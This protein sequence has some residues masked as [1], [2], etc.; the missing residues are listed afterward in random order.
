MDSHFDSHFILKPQ[1]QG[2]G[3][4]FTLCL[5]AAFVASLLPQ[6]GAGFFTFVT[7]AILLAFIKSHW[8]VVFENSIIEKNDRGRF[9]RKV[10]ADQIHHYRINFFDEII[11]L[12]S[13]GRRLVCVESNMTNFDTFRQWLARH[14]I[15]EYSKEK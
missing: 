4:Y 11:L 3:K 10:T 13:T 12:D 8:F 6:I 7:V 5:L 1:N 9:I 15:N 2:L 14:N